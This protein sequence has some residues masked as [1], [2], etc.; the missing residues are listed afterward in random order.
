M[1]ITLDL[2]STLCNFTEAWN[3]WLYDHGHTVDLLTT[4]QITSYDWYTKNIGEHTKQFFLEDPD[5]CYK[6]ITPYPV[7]N[8][9]INYCIINY[10]D[11]EILT[12]SCN[13][14][15]ST[16]KINFCKEHFDF[17]N[18]KFF[19]IMEDKYKQTAGRILIDDYPLHILKHIAHNKSHGIVFNFKGN[20][21][22]SKLQNY[23]HLQHKLKPDMSLIHVGHD[24]M[25]VINHLEYIRGNK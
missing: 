2:D 24:Y 19:D 3:Q 21:G 22:W 18:V 16:A 12:H 17:H 4:E 13:K 10:D 5:S 6:Q 25:D 8:A 11:V 20:F 9:F 7:A 23:Q 15:T 14:R 1:K